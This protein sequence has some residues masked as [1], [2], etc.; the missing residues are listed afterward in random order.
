MRR[1]HPTK[2][3]YFMKQR[4]RERCWQIYKHRERC[5]EDTHSQI[6]TQTLFLCCS[7]EHDL[8]FYARRIIESW[9]SDYQ[10]LLRTGRCVTQKSVFWNFFD[11]VKMCNKFRFDLRKEELWYMSLCIGGNPTWLQTVHVKVFFKQF[12]WY[13]YFRE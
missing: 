4:I 12:W 7:K 8:N 5:H 2:H 6:L 13:E 11:F 10:F 3:H 1:P 9:G